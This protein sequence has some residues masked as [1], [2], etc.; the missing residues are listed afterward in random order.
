M[1]RALCLVVALA[2][3]SAPDAVHRITVS[4]SH[5]APGG[6]LENGR[7]L[8]GTAMEIAVAAYTEETTFHDSRRV[9]RPIEITAGPPERLRVIKG[10][11]PELFILLAASPGPST[12]DVRVEGVSAHRDLMIEAQPP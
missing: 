7:M 12:L 11:A 5:A 10:A 8:E 1:R 9:S 2:G 3:C 6:T 4:T